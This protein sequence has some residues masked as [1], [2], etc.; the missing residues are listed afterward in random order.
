MYDYESPVTLNTHKLLLRPRDGHDLRIEASTLVIS[1]EP[2]VTWYRDELDNSVAIAAF[3]PI[4]TTQL[5][6]R[7]DLTVTHY[8][9]HLGQFPLLPPALRFPF[10][11]SAAELLA[12]SSYRHLD[13]QDASFYAWVDSLGKEDKTLSFLAYLS[14]SIHNYCTYQVR[15]EPGVQT[16]AETLATGRGSCRDY[17]WL[18][19]AAARH[20]GLATRFVSGYCNT[21]NGQYEAPATDEPFQYN[22]TFFD[23]SPIKDFPSSG[24]THAW[25]EVY[26]PGAGWVGVDPTHNLFTSGH[27]TPVAV[28]LNPEDIP[29]VSG[30][31]TGPAEVPK[32]MSV[33]VEV[34]PC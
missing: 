11:Y 20:A 18:F 3:I 4:E 6:I 10:V 13:V 17:A 5:T 32:T 14:S 25:A 28:A 7:S 31:F 21:N 30:S 34:S 29:P 9:A 19:V 12:L 1:P 22:K 15:E 8:T 24:V 23:T 26:L 33:S 16:T 27:H 2:L